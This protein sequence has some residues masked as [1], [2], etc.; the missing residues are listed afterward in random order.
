MINTEKSKTAI[1]L[2]TLYL[3]LAMFAFAVMLMASQ[4]ESLAG[5]FVVLVAMPWTILLTWLVDYLG[6]DSIV[7]N[8]IF[9]AFGC[10][11]NAFI[12]YFI[13]SFLARRFRS[14][15]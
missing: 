9:L 6:I 4:G 1:I 7:F 5:I 13:V 15:G 3:V 11:L 2:T 14:K 8:T 12:L 10:L